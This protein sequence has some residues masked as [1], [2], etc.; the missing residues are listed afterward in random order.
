WRAPPRG[1]ARARPGPR[2]ARGPVSGLSR[3][4]LDPSSAGATISWG[5]ALGEWAFFAANLLALC[6]MLTSSWGLGG[7]FLTNLV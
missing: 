2:R 5:R 4:G 3:T 7:S 6:A 1:R